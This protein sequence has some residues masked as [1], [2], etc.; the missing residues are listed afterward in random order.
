MQY[1]FTYDNQPAHLIFDDVLG[2]CSEIW[3]MDKGV[4][5]SRVIERFCFDERQLSITVSGKVTTHYNDVETYVNGPNAFQF[6]ATSQ[7]TLDYFAVPSTKERVKRM[8]V[9]GTAIAYLG[10]VLFNSETG[11]FE[12][13]IYVP[14]AP[15]AE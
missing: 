3:Y 4:L 11:V 5:T 8:E 7:Q 6:D 9:N 13:A 1:D 15:I 10:M 14:E 2:V 12:P